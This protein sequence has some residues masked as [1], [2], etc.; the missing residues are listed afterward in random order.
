MTVNWRLGED[1]YALK[2]FQTVELMPIQNADATR[3]HNFTQQV[4]CLM[5]LIIY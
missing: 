1:R 2:R 5:Y 4:I 3:L